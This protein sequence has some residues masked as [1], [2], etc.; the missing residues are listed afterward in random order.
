METQTSSVADKYLREAVCDTIYKYFR[1]VVCDRIFRDESYLLF[2]FTLR[3]IFRKRA[4]PV[5]FYFEK[6]KT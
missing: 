5:T 3:T 2:F 4:N 1:D 6:S